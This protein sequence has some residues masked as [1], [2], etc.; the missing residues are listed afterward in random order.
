MNLYY[1]SHLRLNR[2]N[3]LTVQGIYAERTPSVYLFIYFLF[4]NIQ[5]FVFGPLE[6]KN[7]N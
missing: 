7:V 6:R 2:F 5:N 4:P 3:F 1:L